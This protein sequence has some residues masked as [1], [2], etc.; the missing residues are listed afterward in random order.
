MLTV[1]VCQ[2]AEEIEEVEGEGEQFSAWVLLG[3]GPSLLLQSELF[4]E[5]KLFFLS[6]SFQNITIGTKYIREKPM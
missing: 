2:M 5:V 4:E 1:P 3:R 6:Q